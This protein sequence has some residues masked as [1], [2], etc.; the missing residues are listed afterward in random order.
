MRILVRAQIP[1]YAIRQKFEKAFGEK[2]VAVE[3]KEAITEQ[4]TKEASSHGIFLSEAEEVALQQGADCL[5]QVTR[6][7]TRSTLYSKAEVYFKDGKLVEADIPAK[8]NEQEEQS[9]ILF[10][11]GV[12]DLIAQKAPSCQLRTVHLHEMFNLEEP[13]SSPGQE[14]VYGHIHLT[15]CTPDDTIKVLEAYGY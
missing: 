15:G 5:A 10:G 8:L 1:C 3:P 6:L 9:E 14:G 11:H 4:A 12:Q 7:G 2:S 13:G